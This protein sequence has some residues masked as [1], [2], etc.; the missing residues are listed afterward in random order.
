VR[1]PALRP[2]RQGQTMRTA[3]VAIG[4]VAVTGDA[5]CLV[6]ESQRCSKRPYGA[7]SEWVSS[8]AD[9]NAVAPVYRWLRAMSGFRASVSARTW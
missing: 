3:M 2:R 1:L 9:D 5:Q 8:A 7:I 4:V 6:D